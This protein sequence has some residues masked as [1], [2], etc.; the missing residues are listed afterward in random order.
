MT[1][2]SALGV[3]EFDPATVRDGI[4]VD[5]LDAAQIEGAL[6]WCNGMIDAWTRAKDLVVESWKGQEKLRDLLKREMGCE[7][8][9]ITVQ[10]LTGGSI[11]LFAR[12]H[13]VSAARIA[14]LGRLRKE[15]MEASE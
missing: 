14:E 9:S 1:I 12:A 2:E 13:D 6:E 7:E 11:G 5:E 15:L 10:T 4:R 8:T 3:E